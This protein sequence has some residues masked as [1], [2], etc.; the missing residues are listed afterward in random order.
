MSDAVHAV[1]RF[2]RFYTGQIGLLRE[3]LLDSPF[4][5]TESRVLYELAHREDPA[6]SDLVRDL[7]LDAGYLS[8]ILRRFEKRGFVSRKRSRTDGRRS[9]LLMTKTGLKA[10]APLDRAANRQAAAILERLSPAQQVRLVEAMGAIEALMGGHQ[11]AA[12]PYVLRSHRPGDMGAI[13]HLHGALYAREYGWDERFEA[14]VA[15]IAARFIQ[16][17]DPKRERCWVAEKDGAVVGSVF[18]VKQSEEVA[19]LRLLIVDPAARGLGIGQRMVGE[20]IAFAREAGY[21]MITLWTQDVLKA[22]QHI[23]EKS[24]FRLAREEP[25]CAFGIPMVGQIWELKL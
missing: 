17:F 20:L 8:R 1:R 18:L 13:I 22:A 15:E 23:Y 14:L 9:H 25:H 7:A 24:G 2:N 16:N 19:K 3:G 10:F 21:R 11:E 5:L 12:A 6:A 4:S